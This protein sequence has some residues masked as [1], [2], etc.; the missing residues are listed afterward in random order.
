MPDLNTDV[1]YIKGIGEQRAKALAK[2]DIYTLS[3]LVRYFPRTYEDRRNIAD[4][5]SVEPDSFACIKAMVISTPRLN[6]VRK[7]ME[8]TKFRAVDDTG[9]VEITF[10]NQTYIKTQIKMGE[11]YYFYGKLSG[12]GQ[13]RKMPNPLFESENSAGIITRRIVPI[14]RLTSGISQK[15]LINSISSG[16]DACGSQMTNPL[17]EKV[18]E[19]FSLAQ[20]EFAYRNIHFPQDE[21]SLE[22]ARRRLIFEELFV[23]AA[24]LGRLRNRRGITA[25]IQFSRYNA[26]EFFRAMP[27]SP[28][29]AQR[30][31]VTQIFDDLTGG[32]AMNR[33]VQGDV[34]SGKTFVAAAAAWLCW[35]NGKQ[36]AFMAPTEILAEQHFKTMQGF[37]SQFGVRVGLLTGS[38]TPKEKSSVRLA[39]SDGGLDLV[40]GTHALL[41]ESVQF[42]NL[43]LVI[44][45]E[46]HRFGV[47]QRAALNSK[48][49]SVPHVLVMS[50]TPIPR[51]LALMLYGDLDISIIDELPP[52]RQ[53]VD[54]FL[55]NESYR[56]R[57]NSFIRKQVKNGRQVFIVCP[58]VEESEDNDENL[59]SVSEYS[60]RL[61]KNVFPDLR[62]DCLHGKM[63]AKDKAAV[64]LAFSRGETDI[65]VSTTVVEVGV[66][67]PNASLIVIENAER[68]GL[69]QLHQ[70]RGR[71]GRGEHKSYC[72]LIS[73]N[74]KAD[75][76]QRLETLCKTNDGFK[77]S[78]EDLKLRGP[79]DFF[80]SRQHGLPEMHIADL[81][82]DMEILYKAQEA[83]TDILRHDPGLT[84]PENQA[85]NRYINE[86][87]SSNAGIMN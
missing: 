37:L 58:A 63:K 87:F 40:I 81:C 67:I 43:A 76:K 26:E 72:V 54:T 46:Q 61:A 3:D 36:S 77:I 70:L 16:L 47:E 64:M 18:R 82:T 83:A 56:T 42:K 10:F 6:T 13:H 62:V 60:Q 12:F 48:S 39:L 68:F 23:L 28:T 5:A 4:I 11:S 85:L 41:T 31:A 65:L 14:Y 44:T 8:L 50:A 57:I 30:K 17:P 73:N 25:G 35:K 51:T 27:F 22:L 19:K 59:K 86:L 20:T 75:T 38:M 79:G 74:E 52:G 33:L 15:T 78:E 45:D 53:T 32:R 49:A 2:L 29:N 1:R 21:A 71:V 24:A 69:S 9:T 66:D 84:K 55:I 80:G 34:G 7:G